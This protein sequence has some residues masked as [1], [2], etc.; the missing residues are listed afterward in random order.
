MNRACLV[1]IKPEFLSKVQ[2]F[3]PRESVVLKSLPRHAGLVGDL[4]LAGHRQDYFLLIAILT[5]L[6]SIWRESAIRKF[7]YYELQAENICR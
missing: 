6:C 7:V 1:T 3:S 2:A 4:H 5:F